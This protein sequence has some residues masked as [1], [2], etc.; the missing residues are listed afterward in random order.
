[1]MDYAKRGA[2]MNIGENIRR[3]RK[4]LNITQTELSAKTGIKQTTISA[5]ENEINKPAI[6]TII[7]ISV[8]LD[9]TV[10][11]LIGQTS[12][13]VKLSSA[14]R[15]LLSLFSHLNSTGRQR[16]VDTALLFLTLPEYKQDTSFASSAI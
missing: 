16:L 6:E 2:R 5:I 9:C 4:L 11:E 14:D 15:Q 1:M 12:D 3:R 8:A 7:L 10:S 13:Q